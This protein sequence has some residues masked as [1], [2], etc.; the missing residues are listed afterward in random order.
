MPLFDFS[1]PKCEAY[2]LDVIVRVNAD[3]SSYPVC[4]KCSEPMNKEIA[5]PARAQFK[6]SGFHRTDYRAPTRG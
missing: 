2:L 4:E 6:G 3:A 1:C 5:V